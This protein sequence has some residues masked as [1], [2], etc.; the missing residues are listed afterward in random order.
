MSYGGRLIV[1]EQIALTD[2]PVIVEEH[3][4]TQ[5]FSGTPQ[6]LL[7][8]ISP[9][10]KNLRGP[11]WRKGALKKKITKIIEKLNQNYQKFI[12]FN[13]NSNNLRGNQLPA[14]LKGRKYDSDI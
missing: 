9:Q 14:A 13:D 8:P 3:P 1:N 12:L 5:A 6:R 4:K 11:H 7:S 10:I 2:D